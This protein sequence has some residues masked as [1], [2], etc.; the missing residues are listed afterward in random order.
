MPTTLAKSNYMED[1]VLNTMRGSAL[2]AW[3]PYLAL[4]TANPTEDGSGIAEP[5]GGAYARQAV[6]MGAPSGGISA[7]S[8][9]TNFPQATLSWG[10]ITH[11]AI[12][13]AVSGGNMRYYGALE[14][15]KTVAATDT[16]VFD[17]GAL[18]IQE[19]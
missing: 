8:G 1:G 18:T 19:Q 3:T 7:T 14:T 16:L 10:A 13:D 9:A 17:A 12:F 2:A 6:T 4:S 5:S 15:S 11:V